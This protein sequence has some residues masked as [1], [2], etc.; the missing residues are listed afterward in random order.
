MINVRKFAAH[1]L[2]EI[3]IPCTHGAMVMLLLP[4]KEQC[5]S[6]TAAAWS[7]S[8]VPACLALSLAAIQLLYYV[9]ALSVNV[10]IFKTCSLFCEI[11]VVVA[12]LAK[13]S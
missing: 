4:S 7:Y 5:T 6:R 11:T 2:H 13:I 1:I 9:T 10:Q 12:I 8:N 3:H